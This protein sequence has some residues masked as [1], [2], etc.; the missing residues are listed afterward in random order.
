MMRRWCSRVEAG[1]RESEAPESMVE[2][3]ESTTGCRI[4]RSAASQKERRTFSATNLTILRSL[5]GVVECHSKRIE[6]SSAR[7][8]PTVDMQDL[9]RDE[10]GPFEIHDPVDHIADLADAA[11][12]VEAGHARVERGVVAWGPDHS[13]SDGVDSH[14]P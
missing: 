1:H 12:G 8:L 3:S 6:S 5:F 2:S 14:A 13:E 4:E 9:A 10:W 11:E 7:R